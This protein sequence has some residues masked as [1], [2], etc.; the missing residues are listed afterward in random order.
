ML[1]AVDMLVCDHDLDDD[2]WAELTAHLDVRGSIELC[3][4]ATHYDMLATTVAALRIQPDAPRPGRLARRL[5]ATHP[6]PR[7]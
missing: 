2:T 6:G 7:D 1:R 3:L 5:G 4:L